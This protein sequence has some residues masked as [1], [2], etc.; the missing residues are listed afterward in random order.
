MNTHR[1]IIP[2]KVGFQYFSGEPVPELEP[3]DFV[4]GEAEAL[5]KIRSEARSKGLVL[6]VGWLPADDGWEQIEVWQC[7]EDKDEPGRPHSPIGRVLR[8]G[9]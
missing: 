3:A 2:A 5:E 6:G 9:V 4:A 1:Y 7:Q 8:K